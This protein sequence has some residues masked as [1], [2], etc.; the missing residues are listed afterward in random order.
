MPKRVARL[1]A[2]NQGR[3]VDCDDF[4]CELLGYTREELLSLSVWD[5]TPALNEIDGLLMWQEFIRVGAQA[6][7]YWLQRKDGTTIEVEFRAVANGAPNGHLSLLTPVDDGGEPFPQS[8]LP[9]SRRKTVRG[10]G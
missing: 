6:G 4:A 5:L 2:D 3:Y 9:P 1:V 10:S 8:R 7:I